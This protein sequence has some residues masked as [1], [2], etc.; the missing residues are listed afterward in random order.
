MIMFE[1]IENLDRVA[2]VPAYKAIV[3]S[4]MARTIGSISAHIKG[5]RFLERQA[6]QESGEVGQ[7]IDNRNFID[8]D[9]EYERT[10][11][12]GL[13]VI[14]SHFERAR[15]MHSVY[16]WASQQLENISQSKWD[17]PLTLE[18]MLDYMQNNA[19]TISDAFVHALSTATKIAVDDLKRF[20]DINERMEKER[21]ANDRPEI[22][23]VFNSFDGFGSSLAIDELPPITQYQLAGKVVD[24]LIKEKS[25]AITRIMRSKRIDQL[26][27]LKLIDDGIDQIKNWADTFHTKHRTEIDDAI[28]NG[29][30]VSDD[31]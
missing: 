17:D 5:Q 14:P 31:L 24:G 25:R 13:D 2:Q 19:G 20:N 26:A 3:H 22:I 7:T 9:N 15:L 6:E 29:A 1:V 12:Y 28:H 4:S 30:A 10:A 21:F 8:S 18:Q 11:P 16:N 23:D 27:D